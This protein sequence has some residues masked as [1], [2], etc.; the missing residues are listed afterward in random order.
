MLFHPALGG[1]YSV[2]A[3]KIRGGRLAK[4]AEWMMEIAEAHIVNLDLQ[5]SLLIEA[6]G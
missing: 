6:D 5:G 3:Q 1:L 4:R 2:I